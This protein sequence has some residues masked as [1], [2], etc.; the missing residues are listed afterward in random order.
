MGGSKTSKSHPPTRILKAYIEDL[1]GVSHVYCSDD[2]NTL[3]SLKA[4][5]LKMA[6]TVGIAGRM[7]T[8]RMGEGEEPP[9][10]QV[11]PE[12]QLVINVLLMTSS[13]THL[14]HPRTKT[15]IHVFNQ[16]L[17]PMTLYLMLRLTAYNFLIK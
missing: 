12:G 7:Y 11:Q 3:C 8:P 1:M 13:N 17:S 16:L 5:S 9:I 10:A 2:L 4:T 14:A 6:P 15:C